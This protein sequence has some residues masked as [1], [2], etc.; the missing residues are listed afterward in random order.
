MQNSIS[1]TIFSLDGGATSSK[2]GIVNNNRLVLNK[3]GPA[4]FTNLENK[5]FAKNL[6]S[7]VKPY[8]KKY[9]I[10]HFIFGISGIDTNLEQKRIEKLTHKIVKKYFPDST[11]KVMSDID[12]VLLGSENKNKIALIAGTGTN[13]VGWIEGVKYKT[14][15]LGKDLADQG[16][17]YWMS[18]KAIELAVKSYD[19]RGKTTSL[20]TSVVKFYK[21]KEIPDLK[22]LF[23]K[24]D[25]DKSDFAALVPTIVKC[26]SNGDEISNKILEYAGLELAMHVIAIYKQTMFENCNIICTGSI[27]KIEKVKVSFENHLKK[28]TKQ[29]LIN[30]L[31]YPTFSYGIKYF[32]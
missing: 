24:N 32:S 13:C 20:Q 27:F 9:K 4:L 1:K 29:Q 30:Y 22:G 21:V 31:K 26:A 7:I 12:L 2:Y 11:I 10:T 5:V 8:S 15:G 18:K 23:R 19:K 17:G 25:F 14:G 28:H 3:K 16:S 6:I